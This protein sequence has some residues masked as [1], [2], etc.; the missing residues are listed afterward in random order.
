VNIAD[1]ATDADPDYEAEDSAMT[2]ASGEE[3]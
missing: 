3:I 1:G 2:L